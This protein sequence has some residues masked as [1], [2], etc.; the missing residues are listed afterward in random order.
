MSSFFSFGNKRKQETGISFTNP[1]AAKAAHE[2]QIK[3]SKVQLLTKKVRLTDNNNIAANSQQETSVA[4]TSNDNQTSNSVKEI[5]V[6]NNN[7][8]EVLSWADDAMQLDEKNNKKSGKFTNEL[9]TL[10]STAADSASNNQSTNTT[11]L[12]KSSDKETNEDDFIKI[13]RSTKYFATIPAEKVDGDRPDRKIL[14]MQKIFAAALG[15]LGAKHFPQKKE[16]AIFFDHEYNLTKAIEKDTTT[17]KLD[18]SRF[19]VANSKVD[20]ANDAMLSI[21]VTDIPLD[22]KSEVVRSY[23]DQFGKIDKFSMDSR[24][25]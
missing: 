17:N 3:E 16:I 6:E 24:G 10:N 1:E 13:P 19:L 8:I 15:F 11:E 9:E 18:A 23:F 22:T 20:R 7:G 4:S 2:R 12:G 5:Y 21:K 14:N 25:L